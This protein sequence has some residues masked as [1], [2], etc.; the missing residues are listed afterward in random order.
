LDTDITA[1][2]VGSIDTV[3]DGQ[4]G[5]V[6]IS[7][8]S[9]TG[10]V[11]INFQDQSGGVETGTEFAS[12]QGTT[13][14]RSEI[15]PLSANGSNRTSLSSSFPS[16]PFVLEAVMLTTRS[17]FVPGVFT[18]FLVDTDGNGFTDA[19]IPLQAQSGSIVLDPGIRLDASGSVDLFA[20]NSSKQSTNV[21]VAGLFREL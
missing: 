13:F 10:N 1:Q 3:I 12:R 21:E 19:E 4:T 11:D 7:F 6:G 16:S 8:N 15:F 18:R 5:D 20:S 9:Q 14:T 17:E 2:S